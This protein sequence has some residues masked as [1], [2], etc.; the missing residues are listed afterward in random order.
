[1]PTTGGNGWFRYLE[2][3]EEDGK[4]Y[5][6][7]YSPYAASLDEEEKTFFDVNFLTGPGNEGEI[8]IDFDQRFSGM[9]GRS[10]PPRPRASG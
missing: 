1:M 8:S 5:Y 4:I 3:D 6:S 2:F 10:R 7:I 9:A